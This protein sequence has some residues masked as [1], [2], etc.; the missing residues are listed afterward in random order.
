MIAVGDIIRHLESP[1]KFSV[2]IIK[3]LSLHMVNAESIRSNEKDLFAMWECGFKT[4]TRTELLH[5]QSKGTTYQFF[6]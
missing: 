1:E 3:H 6:L 5:W 2:M 4:Q